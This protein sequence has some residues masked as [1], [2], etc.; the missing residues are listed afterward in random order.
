MLLLNRACAGIKMTLQNLNKL[1]DKY[2]QK[3]GV[4]NTE[5][6]EPLQSLPFYNFLDS[7]DINTFNHGIGLPQ[8]NGQS[9]R[10]FDYEQLLFSTLQNHKHV[11]IKK[12][13][14]LGITEFMLRYFAWLC[15]RDNSLKGGR[16]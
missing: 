4:T 10:L 5:Q 14:G 13:T 12:A 6:F 15:V 3:L 8:K 7:A 1:L 2:E 9:F 16:A 11:W